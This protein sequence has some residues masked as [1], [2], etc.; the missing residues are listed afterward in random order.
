VVVVV[1]VGRLIRFDEVRGYGF[2]APSS[3][4]E[5]VFVHA[6]DFGED[7]HR[8]RPGVRVEYEAEESD[9]GLKAAWVKLAETSVSPAPERS[10]ERT[11]ER[12]GADDD[13]LV[14][15]LST[16]E[17]LTALTERLIDDVPSLTGGQIDEVRRSLVVFA[18]GHGW[19]ES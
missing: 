7:R 18:R 8:V 11:A 6:N 19:V 12:V 1:A 4:G 3:G 13:G 2:I 16:K 15:V 5:D 10:G 17:F 14:D 9:R